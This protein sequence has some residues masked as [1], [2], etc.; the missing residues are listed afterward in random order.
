MIVP[1]KK[2]TLLALADRQ[3]ET[4]EAL[5]GLGVMQIDKVRT[6]ASDNALHLADELAAANRTAAAL[7]RFARHLDNA[8]APGAERSAAAGAAALEKASEL[9]AEHDRVSGELDQIRQRLRALAVWGEFDRSAL[10]ALAAKGIRVRLC[11]GTRAQFEAAQTLDGV[12]LCREIADERGRICFAVVASEEVA[13]DALPEIRLGKEDDP[14]ELRRREARCSAKLADIDRS[15]AG[16]LPRMAAVR[17]RIAELDA[18][19]EF[20]QAGDTLARHGAVVS[21]AGFVPQ[22]AI[23]ALRKAAAENGWGLLIEDPAPDDVVPTLLKESRFSRLIAPLFG[24]LGILPG[25]REIDVASGVMVFFTIFYAMIIGD[26]GYGALFLACT[27]FGLRKCR[28]RA[29]AQPPLRLMLILSVATIVWGVLN[30][31]YFGTAPLPQLGLKCLTDSAVKEG[32]TQAFCFIL[33][34]AQ[35]S[36]GRIWRAFHERGIRGIGRNLGWMLVVWGNFFLTMKLVVHPGEFPVFMYYLYGVGLGLVVLCDV[37]WKNPGDVFQFPFSIINSF[38]DVLSYI[39]LFA[40][41]MAGFYIADSFNGMGLSVC[42]SSPWF[43]I[44]GVLVIGFGHL[45]NIGLCFLSVLVHGV[46]L[47]TLEFSNHAGLS[48]SGSGFKPFQNNHQSEE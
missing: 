23:E 11:A 10:D 44:F 46:R 28:G 27:L 34:V 42:K 47:N 43:L 20:A 45:L 48:W 32:N 30:N 17:R 36:L 39:R 2:V 14:A 6:G 26:A 9:L 40:V 21:L 12:R 22:P 29:A 4:L 41:G 25:Y 15:L 24:F 7:E 13:D 5:R 33:A 18:A 16:I 35:L 38:V 19:L 37:N 1:M 3:P 31:N 8:P